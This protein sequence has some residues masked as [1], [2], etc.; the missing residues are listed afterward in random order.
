MGRTK[1]LRRS[2]FGVMVVIAGLFAVA[3]SAAPA[4][5]TST[6]GP[7]TINDSPTPSSPLPS[8]IDVS[9]GSE[10]VSNVTVTL[11]GLAHR[12]TRDLNV[13]LVA[14]N[15]S[16]VVL[17]AQS[18]GC[19]AANLAGVD[20]TFDDAAA[21]SF[22]DSGADADGTWRPARADE[23]PGDCNWTGSFLSPAPSGPYGTTLASVAGGPA[24]GAWK[25]YIEDACS[26]DTGDLASW[27]L[28]LT[29]TAGESGQRSGYCAVAGNTYAFTGAA[30][31]PG[32]FLNLAGGQPD[33]D[34]HYTG[35]LPANYLQGLGIS[36][37]VPAG[38]VK[39]DELVGYFGSGDPG[40][41]IYYKKAA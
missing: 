10:T 15:G 34:P 33:T 23:A 5:F 40:G 4:T 22:A 38:Y 3:A 6:D 32:T 2:S 31:P 7:I 18:G 1:W 39:T 21:A 28:H 11:N 29:T 17:T 26:G 35:A 24:S 12:C 25:L 8:V 20:V 9:A 27:S 19:G 36:C 13:L 14:P 30:I 41:Y 16:N 37:D